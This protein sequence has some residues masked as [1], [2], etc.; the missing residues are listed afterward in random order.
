ME[1]RVETEKEGQQGLQAQVI[2]ITL[3]S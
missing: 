3:E 1:V 2:A